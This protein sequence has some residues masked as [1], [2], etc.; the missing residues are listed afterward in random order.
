MVATP[1]PA[2]GVNES[3]FMTWG[4]IQGTPLRLEMEETPVDIG[5]WGGGA[6]VGSRFHITH[7]RER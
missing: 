3:P 4:D 6:A 1:S 2:P 7:P 5:G